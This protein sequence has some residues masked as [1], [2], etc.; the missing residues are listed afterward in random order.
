ML[1]QQLKAL[2]PYIG[3][4]EK[5]IAQLFAQ[6]PDSALF[7]NLPGAGEVLGRRVSQRFRLRSGAFL[8]LTGGD[9]LLWYRSG[10]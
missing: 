5:E 9:N 3:L 6:H 8:Y 7:N 1:A 2:A 4:Y 10:H